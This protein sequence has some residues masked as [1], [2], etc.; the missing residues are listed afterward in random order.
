MILAWLGIVFV[1]LGIPTVFGWMDLEAVWSDLTLSDLAITILTVI[2]TLGYLTA[3]EAGSRHASWGKRR[4]GLRLADDPSA[5]Q[6]L[7]RNVVKLLPWQFGHMSTAR[8]VN[9]P[10]A[11]TSAMIFFVLS[12]ALLATVALPPLF[13]RRGL[14]DLVSGTRVVR[15]DAGRDHPDSTPV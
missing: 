6:A 7:V 2:P 4:C 5:G 10:E 1:V 14:H 11:T 13:G 8:F 9:V 12:M 3:T 15:D